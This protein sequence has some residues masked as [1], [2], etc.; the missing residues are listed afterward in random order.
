MGKDKIADDFRTPDGVSADVVAFTMVPHENVSVRRNL[1]DYE[2]KVFLVRSDK[3]MWKLPG[4]VIDRYVSLDDMA[5]DIVKELT[6]TTDPYIEY[7][8]Q[9]SDYTDDSGAWIIHHSFLSV[10]PYH[11]LDDFRRQDDPKSVD[12]FS[13][14]QLDKLDIFPNHRKIID[15]V[16]EYLQRIILITDI[17]KYFLT[18]TFTIAE[19]VRNLQVVAPNFKPDNVHQ[20]FLKTSKRGGILEGVI[21]AEGVHLK[22]D[23]YSQRSALLFRFSGQTPE[24]SI[25]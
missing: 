10:I 11:Q 5:T 6:L 18:D 8:G 13:I 4:Q 16:Y 22:S 15:S 12:L 25:Y 14:E 1:P 19:L 9:C 23:K 3:G 24:L 7:V 2:L 21:D 17:A 20:K